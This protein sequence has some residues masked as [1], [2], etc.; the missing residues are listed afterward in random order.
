MAGTPRVWTG[1]V[2]PPQLLTFSRKW[3]QE[4]SSCFPFLFFFFSFFFRCWHLKHMFLQTH[5]SR[6][7]PTVNQ[8]IARVEEETSCHWFILYPHVICQKSQ[9]Q[10]VIR[11]IYFV[12]HYCL[13]QMKNKVVQV[14]K[15]GTLVNQTWRYMLRIPATWEVEMGGFQVQGQLKE[16][17]QGSISKNCSNRNKKVDLRNA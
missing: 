14:L 3:T 15:W 4:I 1:T 12:A 2:K 5:C 9:A 7:F 11:V 16:H 10:W 13:I 6:P 17:S 8:F